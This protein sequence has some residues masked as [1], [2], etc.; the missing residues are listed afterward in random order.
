MAS[1]KILNQA[2]SVYFLIPEKK[3][4][5]SILLKWCS[6]PFTSLYINC[7]LSKTNNGFF[8][9]EV[10]ILNILHIKIC[11]YQICS[12]KATSQ[13]LGHKLK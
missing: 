5:P 12:S 1:F 6:K 2:H 3:N 10:K 4:S 13:H 8:L 7:E 11:S 9:S